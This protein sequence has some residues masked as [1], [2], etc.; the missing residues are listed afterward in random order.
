MISFPQIKVPENL[1]SR[2]TRVLAL[3]VLE[4]ERDSRSL[5]FPNETE[6]CHQL[7]VSRTIL[8]E[9]VKVLA[10]KGMVEARQ[11]LGT[12]AKPRTAWNQLDPDILGWWAELGP[13]THFLRDLCEVRLAI[14]PTASGFAAVRATS[15]EIE[16][17]GRYLKLREAK[18]KASNFGEA[19]DLNLEFHSA[20]AAACHNS[21]LEQLN[22]AISRPLRIALS[23]TTALHASDVLD[24]AA[25]R[26]L[27]EAI[28]THDSMKARAAAERIVGFAMLGVEEV[29]LLE[30]RRKVERAGAVTTRA[31]SRSASQRMKVD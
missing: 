9:A 21:L 28:C 18:V 5:V 6:L 4:A 1:H 12:C 7:G 3:Q 26:Q 15:D 27:Y 31:S 13:D 25:H 30:E 29:I 20:V 19:V 23:Y 14:E 16:A 24:I 2:V 11:K 22:R 17:I 8:R 10:D